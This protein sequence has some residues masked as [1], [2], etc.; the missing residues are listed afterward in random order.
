MQA[1]KPS[2]YAAIWDKLKAEGQV[3]LVVDT[4]N[5][6]RLKK[7]VIKRKDVDASYK[8]KLVEDGVTAKLNFEI[9][10]TIM[11]IKLVRSIG[12]EDII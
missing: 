6:A 3:R 9:K 5:Q 7:A 2:R 8:S 4:S 12:V 1:K 11:T 10:G